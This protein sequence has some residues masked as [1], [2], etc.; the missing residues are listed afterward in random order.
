MNIAGFPFTSLGTQSGGYFGA[1]GVANMTFTGQITARV[2]NGG[3]VGNIY[4]LATGATFAAVAMDTAATFQ[5]S[6]HYEV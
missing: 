6:G 1:V 4:T 2:D 3:T 5:M